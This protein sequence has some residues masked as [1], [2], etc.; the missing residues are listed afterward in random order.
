[1]DIAGNGL[2]PA[3]ILLKAWYRKRDLAVD[4]KIVH[5]NPVA[6]RPLRCS[7]ATFL[8]NKGEHKS[9]ESSDACGRIGVDVSPMVIEIWGGLHAA[10]KVVAKAM[11]FRCTAQILPS[12][13]PAAVGAVR[14]VFSVQLGRSVARQLEALM[15]VST[16]TAKC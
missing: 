11:F 13:R 15:M 1:V 16:D 3:Y 8:K 9:R 14:E 12:A 7:A 6:G 4:L 2:R 10:G 5:P